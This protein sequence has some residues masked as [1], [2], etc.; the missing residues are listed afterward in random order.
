MCQFGP[1]EALFLLCSSTSFCA[2]IGIRVDLRLHLLGLSVS[3]GDGTIF[4]E[5]T[6]LVGLELGSCVEIDQDGT[7]GSHFFEHVLFGHATVMAVAYVVSVLD[8]SDLRAFGPFTA[9]LG[10]DRAF[11]CSARLSDGA[12]LLQEESVEVSPTTVAAFVDEVA[13]HALL[14]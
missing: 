6:T 12:V 9:A 1:L 4:A 3:R 10:I 13:I 14:D 5:N 11:I 8:A 2:H 7:S